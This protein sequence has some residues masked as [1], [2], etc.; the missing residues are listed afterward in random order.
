MTPAEAIRKTMDCAKGIVQSYGPNTIAQ[1][2]RD[3]LCRT[4]EH[5][6]SV[7][8]GADGSAQM[9]TTRLAIIKIISEET[10]HPYKLIET[11]TTSDGLRSRLCDGTWATEAE[12]QRELARKSSAKK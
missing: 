5:Y 3:A 6:A 2:D 12:A 7:A 8:T 9:T 1:A 11:Y 10:S 4:M